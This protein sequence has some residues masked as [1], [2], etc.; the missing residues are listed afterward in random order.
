M[1][2]YEHLLHLNSKEE[3]I[4]RYQ[5]S[6]PVEGF[7]MLSDED[8]LVPLVKEDTILLINLKSR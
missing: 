7:I 4:H 5:L 1:I 2:Q 3:E 8:V 6:S